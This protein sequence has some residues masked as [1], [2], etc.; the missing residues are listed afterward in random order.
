VY[1]A[2][3]R[4]LLIGDGGLFLPG[5]P[6]PDLGSDMKQGRCCRAEANHVEGPSWQPSVGLATFTGHQKTKKQ[7]YL[8]NIL[9]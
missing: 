3:R 2:R 4:W 7:T 8:G 9:I 5:T 6:V 1:K